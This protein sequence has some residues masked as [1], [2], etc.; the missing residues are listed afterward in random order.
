MITPYIISPATNACALACYQ[1]TARSFFP[2]VDTAEI[3]RITGWTPNHIVWAFP[4]WLWLMERGVRIHEYDTIDYVAWA[5]RG[6]AGLAEF[7]DAASLDYVT[8]RTE[9][10]TA[11]EDPLRRCLTHP[12]FAFSRQEPDLATLRRSLSPASVCEVAVCSKRLDREPGFSLHKVVVLDAPESRIV[13]HD[14]V[15]PGAAPR[16]F[17]EVAVEDFMAAWQ[18]GKELTVYER[19]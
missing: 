10:L 17:H 19:V 7:L 16:P 14:P 3:A 4:F 5:E 1:M 15:W 9:N 18:L 13:L 12:N 2:D 8:Q 11:C 6:I